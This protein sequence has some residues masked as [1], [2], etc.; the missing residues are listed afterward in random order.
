MV[1]FFQLVAVAVTPLNL[2]VLPP[3]EDPNPD[4]LIVTEAPI[5]PDVGERFEILRVANAEGAQQDK[6]R[7][8]PVKP[9]TLRAA[10]GWKYI[11]RFIVPPPLGVHDETR[12]TMTAVRL[13]RGL[14][15]NR[16]DSVNCGVYK[17][18]GI[19]CQVLFIKIS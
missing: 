11:T 19:L 8:S 17:M 13:Q 9:V 10:E 12:A 7:R 18:E 2:T 1:V 4:P 14:D 15:C 5:A 3:C 6:R 16:L